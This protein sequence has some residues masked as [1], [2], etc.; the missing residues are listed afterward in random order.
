MSVVGPGSPEHHRRWKEQEIRD[1]SKFLSGLYF[2]LAV[3]WGAVAL[4][5]LGAVSSSGS[6]TLLI[7]REEHMN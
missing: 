3:Q 4:F 2:S 6:G 1:R 5:L 7:M